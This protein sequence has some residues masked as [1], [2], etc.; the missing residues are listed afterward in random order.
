MVVKIKTRLLVFGI[1]GLLSAGSAFVQTD[2]QLP[3]D[4]SGMI[5]IETMANALH[6]CAASETADVWF[7]ITDRGSYGL[8]YSGTEGDTDRRI[9]GI[10]HLDW[11]QTMPLTLGTLFGLRAV[12][13]VPDDVPDQTIEIVTY[14]PTG[15]DGPRP[16]DVV[17]KILKPG[18]VEA[19]L[20]L[21]G[22]ETFLIPGEWRIE[23]RHRG[24]V[25]A[26]QRFDLV[27]PEQQ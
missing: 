13:F 17:E 6:D 4:T 19:A 2:C 8:L 5:N 14:F 24:R 25:L 26:A 7:E 9:T 10:A 18:A 15:P 20:F 23:I 21:I 27:L 16:P 11:A 3:F 1:G 12:G 22:S